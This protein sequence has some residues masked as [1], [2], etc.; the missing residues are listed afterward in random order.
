MLGVRWSVKLVLETE[1]QKFA[2]LRASMAMVAAYYIKLFRAGGRQTQRYFNVSSAFIRRDK[3]VYLAL[4]ENIVDLRFR[5]T[6]L[7]FLAKGKS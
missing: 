7:F 5:R 2:L 6:Y 1:Q 4:V 3:N